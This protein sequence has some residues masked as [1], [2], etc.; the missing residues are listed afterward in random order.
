VRQENEVPLEPTAHV[1]ATR[2][3]RCFRTVVAKRGA[4]GTIVAV[5]PDALGLSF[6]VDFEPAGLSGA[7]ITVPRLSADDLQKVR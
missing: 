5:Q 2:D 1:R 7:K 6:T 4:P 3:I